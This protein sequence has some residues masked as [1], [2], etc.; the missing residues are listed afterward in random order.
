MY[1]LTADEEEAHS[2]LMELP[3]VAAALNKSSK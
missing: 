2:L 1:N 3:D